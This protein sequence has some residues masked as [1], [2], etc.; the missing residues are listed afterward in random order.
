MEAH[1]IK[2]RIIHELTGGYCV[3]DDLIINYST[4]SGWYC[5]AFMGKK[6]TTKNITGYEANQLII[7]SLS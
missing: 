6:I 4:R 7:D 1:E 3:K 2:S 5:K